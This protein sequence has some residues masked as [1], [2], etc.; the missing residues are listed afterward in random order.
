MFSILTNIVN[1]LKKIEASGFKA[2]VVGGFV[3]DF[4]RNKENSDVDICTSAKPDDLKHIF[5]NIF[6]DQYGSVV[7]N[8]NVINFEITTFRREKKYLDNRHPTKIKYVKNL[9]TD[10]K[11]RDFTMNSICLTSDL[12]YIDYLGGRNDINKKIVRMIGKPE[13]RLKED[14]LRILRA[15]RFA[16]TLDFELE[17]SLKNS[18]KKY[19]YLLNNLSFFYKKRELEKIFS[20]SNIKKGLSLISE[21]NLD[22]PLN[23]KNIKNLV[24][25]NS[26]IGIWAQLD[27]VDIYPFTKEETSLI[28]A[29]K[30]LDKK[31]LFDSHILYN[32]ELITLKIAAEIRNINPNLISEKYNHLKIHS[33]RD[34]LINFIEI[35][36][37]LNCS[38]KVKINN[39]MIDIEHMILIDKLENNKQSLTDYILKK[40]S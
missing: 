39:I 17:E 37:L 12:N 35:S 13:K 29:I 5:D 15:I 23:L 4:Y 33:R 31:D 21:F 8:Y 7:L 26:I 24:V 27:V 11:R 34:I 6:I 20:S 10:L 16:T 38:D 22:V 3:R 30:R 25:T 36:S 9:K 14:S 19:G 18:I 28:K 2:Y 40:Y 32:N 1:V